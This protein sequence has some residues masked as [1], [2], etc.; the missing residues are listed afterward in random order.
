ML[1][2]CKLE[3]A[4]HLVSGAGG[5]WPARGEWRSGDPLALLVRPQYAAATAD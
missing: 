4:L 2:V 1:T 5:E 3:E